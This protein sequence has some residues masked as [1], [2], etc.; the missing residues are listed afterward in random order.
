MI[1][2]LSTINYELSTTVTPLLLITGFLGAGKTTL[3]R[4]LV[5][6]HRLAGAECDVI[7]NDFANAELDASTL[8]DGA[9]SIAAIAAS[10]ACCESFDELVALCLKAQESRGKAL[11]IE[12]NGTADPLPLLEAFTLLE[13][14]L[15][16][17]PRWQV[18]MVDARSWGK[19]DAFAALERRQIETATHWVLTHAEDLTA[20]QI[21]EITEQ[22]AG[23]NPH[24]TRMNAAF[25]VREWLDQIGNGGAHVVPEAGELEPTHRHAHSHADDEVHRLSHRFTGVLV[26]LPEHPLPR[27]LADDLLASLPAGVVRAKALVRLAE[28]MP[29]FARHDSFRW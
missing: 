5:S 26:P 24:A 16:F 25:F 20:R 4:S 13:G 19:R 9:A 14:R 7:L 17:F 3:L 18:G 27:A 8:P 1:P 11:L 6:A 15:G 2:S 21:R 12:L 23:V 10:C 28:E 29:R 22:V